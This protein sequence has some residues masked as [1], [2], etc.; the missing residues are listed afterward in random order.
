[1]PE[2]QD[3]RLGVFLCHSSRDLSIARD[4]YHQ[5]KIEKWMNIWFLE[6]NL[7]PSQDWDL[8]IK[9]AVQTS[10][11]LIVL[12]SKNSMDQN[13]TPYPSLPFVLDVLHGKRKKSIP[14][15]ALRLDAQMVPRGLKTWQ[16]IEYFP[17]YQRSAACQNLLDSLRALTGQF[18]TSMDWEIVQSQPEIALQ[19]SPSNWKEQIFKNDTGENQPVSQ[20]AAD[21][22]QK[23][24]E[25]D[26][27][28]VRSIRVSFW[29]IAGLVALLTLGLLRNYL[30]IGQNPPLISN[31]LAKLSLPSPT[32]GIGSLQIS[33]TDGMKMVYVPAGEFI[34]GGDVYYDEKPIHIV[35]LKAFWIDQTEVTNA[36]YAT[37]LTQEGNREEGSETWLDSSDKDAHI[38]LL[39]DAWQ[40]EP[41]YEDHP[42]IEVTWYGANAYCSW[43]GRR[44]PTEAEWEKAARGTK[45]NL[46]PWGNDAPTD[47][48]LN[49]MENLKGPTRVGSYPNGASPYGALD[50]AGNVWEWVADRY[51]QTYYAHS[52]F[53]SPM[54]PESGFFRA[55]RGG[56]WN[57][58]DTYA[59][60]VH[61]HMGAPTISHDF[62]GFRC[63]SSAAP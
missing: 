35:N 50:M 57:Y 24:K 51:S 46:Y 36:M 28:K 60:S 4:L 53:D 62:I 3:Q 18:G 39:E 41:G 23:M 15:I 63:A 29:I 12:H 52:P 56:A 54:G 49:F 9:R 17:K 31:A 22:P 40:P 44:L 55:L 61:R 30:V 43:A 27:G 47:D 7:L 42:V 14:I 10:E 37:F 19:W 34:M 6:A 26:F 2:Y 21:S 38:H 48:L 13:K 45:G 59:R 25:Q 20:D 8:E 1:M 58:R 32:P 5:L 16:V 33:P 11:V